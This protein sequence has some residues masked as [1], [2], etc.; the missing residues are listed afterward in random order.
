MEVAQ[1]LKSKVLCKEFAERAKVK[2][3]FFTR[4]RKVGF[5]AI[6]Y[7]IMKLSKRSSQLTIDEFCRQNTG[8]L[9]EGEGYT[10]QAFSEARQ[11]LLPSAFV[12]LSDDLITRYYSDDDFRT[13]S[14]KRLL[15][16]DGSYMEVPNNE[17]T[18]QRFGCMNKDEKNVAR[19]LVSIVYDLENGVILN[20]LMERCDSNE[21]KLA[22]ENIEKVLA[23]R[24]E[25]IKD[26]L[27]FD[28]GYPSL[29]LIIYLGSKGLNFIMRTS[30][31]FLSEVNGTTTNDETVEIQIT[32]T[33]RKRLKNEGIMID[34]DYKTSLRVIRIMLD[35]GEIE[36][37]I[38][39]MTGKELPYENAKELYF[40]RWRVE[41]K[42]D[43]LKNVLEIENFTGEK[44]ITVEQDFYASILVSNLAALFRNDA[45]EERQ[46]KTSKRANKYEYKINR[47]MLL[48]KIKSNLIEFLICEN[49]R[50]RGRMYDKLISDI[51]RNVVP[52]RTGRCYPRTKRSHSNKYC[53]SRKRY[54]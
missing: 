40:K 46:K 7:A 50:K 10:K 16:V 15:G 39:N 44:P 41:T 9:T 20:A 43:E 25:G 53:K 13:Y 36:I 2:L 35:S 1:G 45:E 52:V 32:S 30:T 12:E 5:V 26:I 34:R 11:K 3:E 29:E 48:G 24:R 38:T 21:R 47:S 8:V 19:A 18:K 17:E 54:V 31:E 4:M 28:R 27:I 37:L 51:Q 33:R 22:M 49:N 23:N 6:L 14:G 42:Y